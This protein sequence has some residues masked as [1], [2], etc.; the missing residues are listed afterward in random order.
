MEKSD[1]LNIT[2]KIGTRQFPMVVARADEYAYRQAEK[3]I[4]ERMHYYADRFP[5]QGSET[6]LMMTLLDVAV[7][8]KQKEFATD[9]TPMVSALEGLLKDL[10]SALPKD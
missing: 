10:E 1:R 8:L 3:L 2:L 5:Q 9:S 6:Y 7:R 4:N